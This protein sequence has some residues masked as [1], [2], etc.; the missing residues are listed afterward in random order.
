MRF[1]P[2]AVLLA[3]CLPA[4]AS[5][6]PPALDADRVIKAQP[7]YASEQPFYALLALGA[8]AETRLWIVVDGD[9]L[10]VDRNGDRDLV[11]EG[12]K[13]TAVASPDD[14]AGLVSRSRTWS[15]PELAVS[16]RYTDLKVRFSLVNPQWSPAAVAGNRRQMRAFMRAV[17]ETPHAQL[18]N[19]SVMIDR[20][21]EQQSLNT[22]FGTSPETAPIFHMDAP[23]TLGL[24][25]AWAPYELWRERDEQRLA[26]AV[27]TPGVGPGS[28]S[29]LRY[30]EL[31]ADLQPSVEITFPAAPG[32]APLAPR[33]FELPGRC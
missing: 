20:T 15:V 12:E 26:V 10:Y 5:A 8:A 29:F 4:G 3:A 27:G 33:R 22:T 1:L 28:F 16:S 7:R 14:A 25:E 9:D 19:V 13:V 18:S 21:R 23:L 24:V 30:A 31:P 32:A 11:D 17:R 2:L 6:G